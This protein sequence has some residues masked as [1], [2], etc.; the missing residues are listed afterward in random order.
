[1]LLLLSIVDVV[2]VV[3]VVVLI[4][5]IISISITIITITIITSTIT[6]T[7][8]LLF[9][10]YSTTISSRPCSRMYTMRPR[11][12][13]ARALGKRKHSI[14]SYADPGNIVHSILS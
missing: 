12:I 5:T 1:M 14:L 8:T 6:S 9:N 4:I 7:T 10:D 2:V 13:C 3:V 11:W